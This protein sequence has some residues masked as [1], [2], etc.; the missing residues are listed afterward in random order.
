MPALAE[1]LLRE[2]GVAGIPRDP[3]VL[4]T[5]QHLAQELELLADHSVAQPGGRGDR[6]T[7]NGE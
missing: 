5:R 6:R 4:G 3:Q 7:L 1:L 2:D